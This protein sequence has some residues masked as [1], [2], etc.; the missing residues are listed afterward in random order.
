MEEQ[1]A[2]LFDP[3]PSGS[4]A[5]M[6]VHP[7]DAFSITSQ[8]AGRA[9]SSSSHADAAM[10][11]EPPTV[12]FDRTPSH[13]MKEMFVNPSDAF[14][15]TAA[16]A[17]SSGSAAPASHV[18]LTAKPYG[19]GA[20][21]MQSLLTEGQKQR[22]WMTRNPIRHGKGTERFVSLETRLATDNFG[23]HSGDGSMRPVEELSL[24]HI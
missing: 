17:A 3:T 13:S 9:G 7:G 19:W 21:A 12:L 16:A 2:I 5:E 14:S 22:A 20:A 24:I 4:M 8:T 15:R 11:V 23:V 1:P 10:T 6:Y 18:I